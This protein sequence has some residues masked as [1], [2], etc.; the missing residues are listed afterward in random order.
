MLRATL[1][2]NIFVSA[3][4][5]R[6][7]PR[8]VL[9]LA[10]DGVIDVA[11]S[12]PILQELRRVVREKFNWPEQDIVLFESEVASFTRHVQP[13]QRIE[14][15]KE[16]ET[17]NRILECAVESGSEYLVTGDK[18]LLKLEQFAGVK[19]LTPADFLGIQAQNPQG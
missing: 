8:E 18:H 13:E 1:D 5:F 10:R 2:T 16:D 9:Q 6:G 3:L 19:I 4:N 15:V 11:I 14:A 12:A 17:D 7:K